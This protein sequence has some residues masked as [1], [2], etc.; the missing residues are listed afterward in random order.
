MSTFPL[1]D[2]TPEELNV[3]GGVG[4]VDAGHVIDNAVQGASSCLLR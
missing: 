3:P 2:I 4:F 1:I